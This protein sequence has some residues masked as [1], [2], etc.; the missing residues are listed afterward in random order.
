M[1]STSERRRKM[2]RNT[3][4]K[5]WLFFMCSFVLT[6]QPAHADVVTDWNQ[7]AIRAV[8][9]AGAPGAIQSR[10]LALVHAAMFDAVNAIDRRHE[11]YA[12]DLKANPGASQEA[13]AA[14]AA[15][16]VLT[17]LYWLQTPAFDVALEAS[18][19]AIPAGASKADGIAAGREVAEKSM[20][21]RSNDGA[22]A[23]V[24]YTPQQGPGLYQ[25]TPPAFAPVV[26]P[27]WGGVKPFLLKSPGQI[28]TP[29]P[30]RIQQPRVRQ[31]L[32]RGQAGRG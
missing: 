7:T 32:E 16:G 3:T 12:V 2:R 28:Q 18:L 19:A 22:N 26:L 5:V 8:L 14:A 30:P 1:K 25:L 31:G 20:A 13:A 15:Y 29:G 17:R 6:L 4:I 11:P 27:H 21:L 23:S 10:N 9:A 24:T